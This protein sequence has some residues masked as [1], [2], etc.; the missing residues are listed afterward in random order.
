MSRYYCFLTRL[1]AVILVLFLF[2]ANVALAQ[3]LERDSLQIEKRYNDIQYTLNRYE[4]SSR[5]IDTSFINFHYDNPAITATSDYR[6]LGNLGAPAAPLRFSYTRN[7]GFYWGINQFAPYRLSPDSIRYFTTRYPYSEIYYTVGGAEGQKFGFHYAQPLFKGMNAYLHFNSL[8]STGN[9]LRQKTGHMTTA[10]SLHYRTPGQRYNLLAH[11]LLN[12]SKAQQNGGINLNSIT[13]LAGEVV[14]LFEDTNISRKNI[15]P[16]FLN[17]AESQQK[18]HRYMLQN[19][20]DWGKYSEKNIND[21][22]TAFILNP[23]FRI[24]HSFSYNTEKWSYTDTDLVEEDGFYPAFYLNRTSTK[25]STYIH[26]IENEAF[27]ILFGNSRDTANQRRPLLTLRAGLAHQYTWLYQPSGQDTIPVQNIVV[28][29]TTYSANRDTLYKGITTN[30]NM[31]STMLR[32]HLAGTPALRRFVFQASGEYA[33]WGFNLADFSLNGTLG[34]Q[35]S[36]TIGQLQATAS[37]KNLTPPALSNFYYSN[38]HQWLTN[39]SKKERVLLL[40]ADYIQPK[41]GLHISYANYTIDNF[42]YWGQ[43]TLPKQLGNIANIS[44]FTLQ[45]KFSLFRNK[46]IINN[47]IALQTDNTNAINLPRYWG[48]HSIYYLTSLFKNALSLQI[49]TDITY[50]TPFYADAYVPELGLFVVQQEDKLSF[51]PIIDI[52]A[53]AKIKRAVIFLKMQHINQGIGNKGGYFV[54]PR[55]A[56]PD[57]MFRL[58]ISWKFYS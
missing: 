49:G 26:Q 47:T 25:D 12:R 24:G 51:Y 23:V 13:N 46:L 3:I 53:A 28:N 43:D 21:T 16:I 35:I 44:L 14:P 8:S 1:L 34:Y 52:Y 39:N 29:N 10:V 9:Y 18:Q 45:K 38:H 27:A 37:L 56:A 19:T 58:G 55:Y 31:Q 33:L 4:W 32:V 20:L 57:R 22:A 50:N 42:F 2:Q 7:L 41:W 17:A 36:P 30:Q 54:A 5:L 6:Y 48:K 40:K 15:I 11:F